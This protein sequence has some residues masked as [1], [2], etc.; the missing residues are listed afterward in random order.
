MVED[1]LDVLLELVALCSNLLP[2]KLQVNDL[3]I[4][5]FNPGLLNFIQ[6]LL[7]RSLSIHVF[8]LLNDHLDFLS[9]F[10]VRLLQLNS[11][12]DLH[13]LHRL[14]VGL[15]ILFIHDIHLILLQ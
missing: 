1:L 4:L 14:L 11:L 13:L 15:E 12:D 9:E 7:L 2:V 5:L 10:L 3:L 8:D 6:L